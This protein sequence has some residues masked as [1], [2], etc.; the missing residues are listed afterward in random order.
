M[1]AAFESGSHEWRKGEFPTSASVLLRREWVK[2]YEVFA[3]GYHT[4]LSSEQIADL[5]HAGRLRRNHRCKPVGNERWRTIDELFPLLKYDSTCSLPPSDR[6]K[7][8]N[9]TAL[10]WTAV[11]VAV[12]VTVLALFLWPKTPLASRNSK[13]A[14]LSNPQNEEN[15]RVE[16]AA[17]RNDR[18]TSSSSIDSGHDDSDMKRA[19]LERERMVREQ[20][21]RADAE[22]AER[23]RAEAARQEELKQKAAGR[24][25]IVPLDQIAVIS[26]VGGASVTVKVHDNDVT[27]FDVWVNGQKRSEVPK[28]KGISHSRT[29]ETLI[30]SNRGGSLYYVWEISGRLNSCLL[31]VRND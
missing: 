23:V 18:D 21:Q 8:R 27:S 3:D 7:Q 4:P 13:S 22:R 14:E 20:S 11:S 31:R 5:F 19:Q 29:D 16:P 15:A 12:T 26:D 30:Y 10:I 1:V 17:V 25:V 28:N 24:D 6:S 2:L 9:E